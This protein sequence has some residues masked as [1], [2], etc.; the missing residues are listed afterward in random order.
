MIA[1]I[2]LYI[3]RTGRRLEVDGVR[4]LAGIGQFQ[5]YLN[6]MASI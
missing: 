2:V 5:R 1:N 3:A 4:D 6:C